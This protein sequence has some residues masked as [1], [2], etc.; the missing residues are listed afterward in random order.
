MTSEASSDSAAPE[1]SPAAGGQ[2]TVSASLVELAMQN[3]ALR[4][5]QAVLT[6][7][8]DHYAKLYEFAPVGYLTLSPLA[9]IEE[10]NLTGAEL[11]GAERAALLGRPFSALVVPEDAERWQRSFDSVLQHPL[12]PV[13]V[14]LSLLRGNAASFQARLDCSGVPES[15]PLTEIRIAV[16]DVSERSLAHAALRMSEERFRNLLHTVP[17][18]AVQGYSHDGTTL[19][20]NEAAVQLFGYTREEAIGRNVLDLIIPPE[21]R[22]QTR[23]AIARM[24]TTSHAMPAAERSLM[25]RDGSRVDV[26]SSHVVIETPG[27]PPEHFCL[28]IDLSERKKM[29]ATLREQEEFFRLISENLGDFVAVLDVDGHRLYNSPSYQ[30]F[31]DEV[32]DL[33]GTDSFVEIHSDDRDRVRQVFRQTVET[34]VGQQI[35][36]RFVDHKGAVHHMES[37]GGVIRDRDGKV[38]RVMVIS[39]DITVRKLAEEKIM[40]LAF[41]DPLTHL[42][43]RRLLEDRLERSVAFGARSGRHAAVMFIDLDHFK[44]INDQFGHEGGDCV[45]RQVAERLVTCVREEDTVARWGGDEFVVILEGLH[46]DAEQAESQARSVGDKI[47]S[48]LGEPYQLGQKS[49]CATPSIGT[50]LYC[51]QRSSAEALLQ[52]ADQAMYRAKAEGRNTQR[53]SD[54]SGDR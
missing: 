22:E 45:L 32:S 10:I 16:C 24:G 52:K 50:T 21:L 46:E 30:R 28:D 38:I 19:Y 23:R 48:V 39:R 47:L 11:L 54:A 51:G 2:A 7:T 13:N 40:D 36:Y 44:S 42:P 35:E 8:C 14:E 53:F 49:C 6:R 3:D 20:W 41:N 15:G 4:Q 31:I 25:R 26:F 18:V 43:N 34:G 1:A 29:E 17:A 5:A 37:R 9:S 27:H 33:L 12:Q